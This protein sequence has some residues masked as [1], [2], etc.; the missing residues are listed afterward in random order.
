MRAVAKAVGVSESW[1]SKVERAL[2]V[3]VGVALL[4]RVAA[5]VGLDLSL[6]LY[7]GGQPIRDARQASLL[8]RLR[9]ELN[10]V[11]RWRT[12]VPL[13]NPGDQRAWD[14]MVFG[15]ANVW[16]FGVEAETAPTDG[17]ALVRR[18]ALKA[19][20][21]GVD[22]VLLLLPD[23]RQSRAFR[24]EFG[25]LLKEDFPVA[26]SLALERLRAGESPGGSAMIV[27]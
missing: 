10:V 24:R 26:G 21:A 18:L 11:L 19:R 2:V 6:R 9:R 13:P 16:R 27:R 23:T 8:E 5:V 3:N 1:I 25:G 4:A 20:D 17:Q 15:P 12:E 7:P 14:G 22:G